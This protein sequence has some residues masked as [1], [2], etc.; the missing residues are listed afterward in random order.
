MSFFLMQLC[1]RLSASLSSALFDN[2]ANQIR[3]RR[4]QISDFILSGSLLGRYVTSQV[5]VSVVR[6]MANAL[7]NKATASSSRAGVGGTDGHKG[8]AVSKISVYPSQLVKGRL[9]SFNVFFSS[10]ISR[11]IGR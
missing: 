4:W 10:P 6:A 1:S 11:I 9:I 2:L 7:S 3:R 5:V 8:I